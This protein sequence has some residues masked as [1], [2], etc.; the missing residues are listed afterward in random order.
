MRQRREDS[1]YTT[2]ATVAPK[3]RR[4][5]PAQLC[6]YFWNDG[7]EIMCCCAI[8]EAETFVCRMAKVIA[9]A[10]SIRKALSA[11]SKVVV[12]DCLKEP[13]TPRQ[14]HTDRHTHS[15]VNDAMF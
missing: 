11:V 2:E 6:V 9:P 13:T 3:K 7:C 4:E 15:Q 5:A 8:P 10:I 1:D 14:T 12:S